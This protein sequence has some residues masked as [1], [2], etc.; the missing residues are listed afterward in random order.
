MVNPRKVFVRDFVIVGSMAQQ[1]KA[2]GTK[3]SEEFRH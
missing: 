1:F 2:I 3:R